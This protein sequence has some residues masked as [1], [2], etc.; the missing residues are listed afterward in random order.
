LEDLKV[1]VSNGKYTFIQKTDDWRIHVLRYNEPWLIIED[2]HKA[3]LALMQAVACE[4][5]ED[6]KN[7]INNEITAEESILNRENKNRKVLAKLT[8]KPLTLLSLDEMKNN[9][10]S[11]GGLPAWENLV[12]KEKEKLLLEKWEKE[13]AL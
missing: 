8:G 13:S 6:I 3:I 11:K 12:K 4:D 7:R 9:I 1:S 10:I 2:G 5:I